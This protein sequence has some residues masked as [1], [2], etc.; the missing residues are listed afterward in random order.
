MLARFRYLSPLSNATHAASILQRRNLSILP[1]KVQLIPHQPIINMHEFSHPLLIDEQDISHDVYIVTHLATNHRYFLKD[2]I[3]D[4]RLPGM[5]PEFAR[6]LAEKEV[7]AGRIALS[8]QGEGHVP[9]TGLVMFI[10]SDG[11]PRY[12]IYSKEIEHYVS[13][14]TIR[15]YLYDED[16]LF[17]VNNSHETCITLHEKPRSGIPTKGRI[18]CRTVRMFLG[19]GDPNNKNAGVILKGKYRGNIVNIDFDSCFRYRVL[20]TPEELA[21]GTP[22]S[23]IPA[24]NVPT[25]VVETIAR[26]QEAKERTYAKIASIDSKELSPYINNGFS[27]STKL[28]F[29]EE[30]SSIH[31]GMMETHKKYC[32]TSRLL[33]EKN[34]QKSQMLIE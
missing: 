9:V 10:Q 13:L 6:F 33:F 19:E 31:D 17:Y 16:K 27:E 21:F 3:T 11:T 2:I 15:G 22:K 7:L 29:P 8:I 32:E 20:E 34:F 12:F 1:P 18:E 23:I 28:H 26:R 14:D 4:K 30:I 5:S 24:F 25:N